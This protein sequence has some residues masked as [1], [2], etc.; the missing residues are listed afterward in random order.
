MRVYAHRRDVSG[1]DGASNRFWVG[2]RAGL[3]RRFESREGTTRVV[4]TLYYEDVTPPDIR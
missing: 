1:P 2:A 4:V 3:P